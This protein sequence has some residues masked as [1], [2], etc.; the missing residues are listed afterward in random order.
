MKLTQESDTD[1]QRCGELYARNYQAFQ[2]LLSWKIWLQGAQYW[3]IS[4]A[5]YL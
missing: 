5:C 4:S 1:D 2:V 3:P